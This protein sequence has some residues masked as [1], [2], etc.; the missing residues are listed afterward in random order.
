MRLAKSLASTSAELQG[1]LGCASALRELHTS[2]RYLV[3]PLLLNYKAVL[4]VPVPVLF[5][6]ELHT[7]S[8][9]L[10]VS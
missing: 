9:Y 5:A 4:V 6:R 2:S 8:R 3:H 1:R 10:V 7:S